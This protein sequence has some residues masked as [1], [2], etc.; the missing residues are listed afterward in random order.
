MHSRVDS[1]AAIYYGQRQARNYFKAPSEG[2]LPRQN[3]A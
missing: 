2:E 1:I 3:F